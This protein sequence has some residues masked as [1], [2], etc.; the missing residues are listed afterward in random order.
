M[1]GALDGASEKGLNG[2]PGR[3]SGGNDLVGKALDGVL[4]PIPHDCRSPLTMKKPAVPKA[5]QPSATTKAWLLLYTHPF[6]NTNHRFPNTGCEILFKTPNTHHRAF[7]PPFPAA[8]H[9]ELSHPRERSAI[10]SISKICSVISTLLAIC[11][12]ITS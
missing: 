4:D 5:P 11:S 2:A 9:T 1:D 3:L 8:Y 6:K 12:V 7:P 10:K